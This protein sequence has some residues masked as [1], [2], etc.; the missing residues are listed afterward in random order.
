LPA[1]NQSPR[2]TTE[3]D[4]FAA[5]LLGWFDHHGR[6]DLPWQLDATPYR[7]WVSEIMLQ[8]TQVRTVIPYYE[9]FM[10]RFPELASLAA[11]PVDDVLAH[12]SGLGYYARARN[13]HR[14]AGIVI[15]QHDGRLPAEQ[16]ALMELP[17]IGRSTA[18]AILALSTGQQLAILDGN[19]KRVLARF[20]AIA[21]WPGE[22]RVAGELWSR[23]E[24][25]TP[26]QRV[27]DY[28]QAIMDLGATVC[29]RGQPRCEDCPVASD[30]AAHAAGIERE[31]PTSRK[32]AERR[33]RSVTV[34]VV[35]NA[36]GE[37]LLERR[38]ATGI[39]GGLL[40]FPELA[41]DEAV[42]DWCLRRL[43]IEPAQARPLAAVEHSFTHFD[44]TLEPVQLELQAE[45]AVVMDGDRWL[46]YNSDQPLP[47]G[48]AAPIGKILR[49]VTQT[50]SLS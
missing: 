4:S 28:T 3:L 5:R 25:H 26:A 21:G 6:H 34:L 16:A 13:L 20:H 48:I 44:L 50:E 42:G 2:R 27:A 10:A 32:R 38:P 40:S 45:A 22:T 47:G 41:T 12:W 46:W 17:G 18:A 7:I 49:E 36:A 24:Q 35:Q 11:A 43:G 31:L 14:A 15:E 33:T 19:V 37:T 23:A 29:T 30:C 1:A 39:W 8:Q 9:R